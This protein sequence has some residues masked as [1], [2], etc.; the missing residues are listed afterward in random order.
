MR[1]RLASRGTPMF[2]VTVKHMMV[3][4]LW[5]ISIQGGASDENKDYGFHFEHAELLMAVKSLNKNVSLTPSFTKL[6]LRDKNCAEI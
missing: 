3:P 2:L 1:E 6:N 4:Y 5:S